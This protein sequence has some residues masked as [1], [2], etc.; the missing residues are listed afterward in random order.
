MSENTATD[1]EE[2][3]KNGAEDSEEP[4]LSD[5][6]VQEEETEEDVSAELEALREKYLRLSADLTTIK[7]GLRGEKQEI[8]DFGKRAEA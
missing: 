6:E 5:A 2:N 8:L 3:K 4:E 1:I 7:K